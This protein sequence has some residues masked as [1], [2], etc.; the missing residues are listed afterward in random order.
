MP[1]APIDEEEDIPRRVAAL[2]LAHF[3]PDLWRWILDICS[4]IDPSGD[5]GQ[6]EPGGIPASEE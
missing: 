2:L 4:L 1:A 3:M 6:D 5:D